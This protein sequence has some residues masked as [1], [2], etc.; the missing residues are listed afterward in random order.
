MD[1]VMEMNGN[2]LANPVSD[3]FDAIEF[4]EDLCELI[5]F[6]DSMIGFDDSLWYHEVFFS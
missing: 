1:T 5:G 2:K 3:V 4:S 6:H